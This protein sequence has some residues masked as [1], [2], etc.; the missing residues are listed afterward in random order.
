M[1]DD[2]T[3]RRDSSRVLVTTGDH[4]FVFVS[5]ICGELPHI[6]FNQ[7][8]NFNLVE[9]PFW[10]SNNVR[11]RIHFHADGMCYDGEGGGCSIIVKVNLTFYFYL[12]C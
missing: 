11:R 7:I 4:R 12:M 9:L 3:A 10:R 6:P 8:T 5:V 1:N 2:D